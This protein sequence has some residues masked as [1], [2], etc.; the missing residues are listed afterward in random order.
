MGGFGL[1]G[2]GQ[3][4]ARLGGKLAI[5]SQPGSGTEVSVIVP[6]APGTAR[7]QP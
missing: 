2:M 3:R 4:A 7:E 6:V 5:S 1:M